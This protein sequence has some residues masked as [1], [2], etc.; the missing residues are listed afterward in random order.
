M[1]SKIEMQYTENEILQMATVIMEKRALYKTSRALLTSPELVMEYLRMSLI[2]KNVE[3]FGVFWLAADTG[4]IKREELFTGSI[5][6]TSVYPGVV[7]K[8]ALANDAV[9]AIFYHNHPSG[10]AEPSFAD[11]MLTKVLWKSLRLVDVDMVDHLIVGASTVFSYAEAGRM[12]G[13]PSC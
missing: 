13:D 12:R 9:S 8:A 5:T 6:A 7:A 2:S 10:N 3:V 4:L 1:L 11:D